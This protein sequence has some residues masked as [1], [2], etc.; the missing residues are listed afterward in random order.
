[1]N[2]TIQ[3]KQPSVDVI[4]SFNFKA[5]DA[6]IGLATFSTNGKKGGDSGHG[7]WSQLVL[8]GIDLQ[9]T[10]ERGKTTISTQGDAESRV[11]LALLQAVGAQGLPIVCR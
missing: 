1:M 3:S 9:V 6:V 4:Q 5:E 7:G 8:E 10:Q 2:K 11:L